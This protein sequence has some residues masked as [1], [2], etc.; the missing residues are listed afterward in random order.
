MGCRVVEKSRRW[1]IAQLKCR[2]TGLSRRWDVAQ[3]GY[4]AIVMSRIGKVRQMG[5][6]A[7]E[8]SRR[9]D[10]A[11]KKCR[12]NDVNRLF[13]RNVIVNFEHVCLKMLCSF[14]LEKFVKVY[15]KQLQVMES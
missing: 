9:W 13:P 14:G 6:R 1:D 5:C 7:I 8:M 4:R 12:A 15:A 2:A 10:I 11:Q 3:M